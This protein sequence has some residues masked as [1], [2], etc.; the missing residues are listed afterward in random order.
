MAVTQ[1]ICVTQTKTQ[2]FAAADDPSSVFW[3]TVFLPLG[4]SESLSSLSLSLS[5][6]GLLL[7]GAQ[8]F[9]EDRAVSAATGGQTKK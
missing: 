6:S 2:C 4:T 5:L 9:T 3:R 7:A 8:T 1:G